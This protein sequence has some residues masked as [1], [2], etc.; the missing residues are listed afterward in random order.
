MTIKTKVHACVFEP[1]QTLYE[2]AREVALRGLNS[3]TQHRLDAA[4]IAFEKSA[5]EQHTPAGE[6]AIAAAQ[7]MVADPACMNNGDIDIDVPGLHHHNGEDGWWVQAWVYV[8]DTEIAPQSD[9]GT[10]SA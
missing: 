6:K 4:I 2:A 3:A 7:E 10:S 5:A 1:V 9:D 8:S